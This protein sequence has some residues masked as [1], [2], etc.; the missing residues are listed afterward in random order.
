MG[1]MHVW[2]DVQVPPSPG[3]CEF[4]R[5]WTQSIVVVS[6]TSVWPPRLPA[7][8]ELVVQAGTHVC[9]LV[10]QARFVPQLPLP[11]HTTHWPAG[12]Q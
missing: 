2:F 6:Q 10:S 5:H 11:T 7:H 1:H 8:W 9:A 4:I 12:E 3:H